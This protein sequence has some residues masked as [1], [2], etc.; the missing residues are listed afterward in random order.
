VPGIFVRKGRLFIAEST[1]EIMIDDVSSSVTERTAQ[2]LH[3]NKHWMLRE[4]RM[5]E[6]PMASTKK[7]LYLTEEEALALL[8]LCLLSNAEDDPIKE[9]AVRKVSSICRE[10]IRR[11][12][13]KRVDATARHG[14]TCRTHMSRCC[15]AL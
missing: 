1:D 8:D 14:F 2:S 6:V 5:L 9:Q 13:S 12:D 10:F 3:K 7:P 4:R 15:A 11:G